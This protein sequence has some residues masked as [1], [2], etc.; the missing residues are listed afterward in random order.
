MSPEANK[1]LVSEFYQALVDGDYDKAGDMCHPDFVFYNQIDTPRTGAAGFIEAEKKH[2]DIFP[3][4]S[5]TV[6]TVAEGDRVAAYVVFEG[7]Q[8]SEYYGVSPQGGHLRMSMCNL[9]TVR[10]GKFVE[11]RAH[12]DRLDHIEQLDKNAVS[13]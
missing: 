4:F 9:F 10:N 7:D 13:A 3:G 2:L 1:Q 8:Q 11:K 5:M 12:Y 6:D